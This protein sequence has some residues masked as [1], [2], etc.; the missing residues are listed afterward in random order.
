M[1]PPSQRP[2][3]NGSSPRRPRVSRSRAGIA[4]RSGGA[5]YRY[6]HRAYEAHLAPDLI[7]SSEGCILDRASLSEAGGSAVIDEY[8]ALV[9][10]IEAIDKGT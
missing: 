7:G 6:L 3:S 10:M 1:T 9:P 5:L 8:E 2:S 4:N